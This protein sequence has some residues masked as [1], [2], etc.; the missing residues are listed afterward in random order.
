MRVIFLKVAGEYVSGFL[1]DGFDRAYPVAFA[2]G[3]IIAAGALYQ[4][5]VFGY[6]L[7]W[8]QTKFGHVC[9]TVDLML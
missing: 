4:A 6:E 7:I 1:V 3:V 5:E 9:F 2:I 8:T